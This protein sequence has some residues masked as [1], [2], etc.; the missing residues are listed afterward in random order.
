MFKIGR[1]WSLTF[2]WFNALFSAWVDGSSVSFPFLSLL[3]QFILWQYAAP[4]FWLINKRHF[5]AN[6]TQTSQLPNITD[7]LWLKLLLPHADYASSISVYHSR[8]GPRLITARKW[9]SHDFM[10]QNKQRMNPFAENDERPN[11]QNRRTHII[12]ITAT[13]WPSVKV[14]DVSVKSVHCI[15]SI[16]GIHTNWLQI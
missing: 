16:N 2:I 10:E 9:L 4:N 6:E 3:W 1:V 12:K 15:H 5:R 11:M 13:A 7:K 8:F 14:A